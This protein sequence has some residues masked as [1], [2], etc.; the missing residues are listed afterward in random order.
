MSYSVELTNEAKQNLR[1]IY[2]YIAFSLLEPVIAKKLTARIINALNSLNELP[3]RY[4][5]Y[6]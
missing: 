2:E 1:N 6:G 4:P 5:L 3:C